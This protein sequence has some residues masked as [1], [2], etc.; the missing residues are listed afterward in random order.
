MVVGSVDL[1][2]IVD[3][4]GDFGALAELYPEF[5][6]WEPYCKLYPSLFRDGHWV[7]P[8]TCYLVRA[9]GTVVLV[10]T[11]FGPAG[12][13]SA[14]DVAEGLPAG[15]AAAGVAPEDV[16]LVFLTHL[17][18]DHV[19]WN[20]DREARPLFPRARY[21]VHREARAFVR[22]DARPHVAR[23]I[24][25]IEFEELDGETELAAEVVAFPLPGH[26]PGHMGVRIDSE[27]ERAL[28]IVDTAVQPAQLDQPALR[29]VFDVDHEACVET[30]RRL[31]PEIVDADVL[32]ACGH[33]PDGGIGRAVRRDG[34]VVWEAA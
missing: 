9:S 16:D 31:L 10:D 7:L 14:W 4:L 2:P 34:R 26:Y 21:L 23:C 22:G 8:C 5:D 19:G 13:E 30:R 25:P 20:T 17:H 15:L 28:L 11:G 12:P 3:A 18:I 27:G 24:E 6:A 32:V 33:Y 29:Y 1:V